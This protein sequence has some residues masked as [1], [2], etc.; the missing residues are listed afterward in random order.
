MDTKSNT[1]SKTKT[2]LEQQLLELGL[3]LLFLVEKAR[4]RGWLSAGARKMRIERLLHLEWHFFLHVFCILFLT[5]LKCSIK[6]VAELDPEGYS[7][8]N[9]LQRKR[10]NRKERFDCTSAC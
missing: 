6:L 7:F 3:E 4:V 1:F 8:G 2:D 10:K 5:K 9:C